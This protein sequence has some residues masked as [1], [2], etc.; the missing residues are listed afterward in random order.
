MSS[1]F[2]VDS[3][4]VVEAANA[5]CVLGATHCAWNAIMMQRMCMQGVV[6]NA[7]VRLK[8]PA[9]TCCGSNPEP[10]HRTE[11]FS[12]RGKTDA[13]LEMKRNKPSRREGDGTLGMGPPQ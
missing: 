11:S 3:G 12:T 13:A 8:D 5:G 10:K 4:F 1:S 7:S 9:L 2:G 6:P